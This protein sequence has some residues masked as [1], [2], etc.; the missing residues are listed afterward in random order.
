MAL[1]GTNQDSDD[2]YAG[3]IAALKVLRDLAIAEI[4]ATSVNGF[5]LADLLEQAI[6]IAEEIYETAD[7]KTAL[8]EAIND[9]KAVVAAIYDGTI[10]DFTIPEDLEVDTPILGENLMI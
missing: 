2:F 1:Q 4:S 3:E 9:S 8:A 7:S 5:V 6:A 10:D